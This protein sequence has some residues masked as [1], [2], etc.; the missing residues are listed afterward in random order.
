[1]RDASMHVQHQLQ[2]VKNIC[3]NV[4][5]I[6]I[7]GFDPKPPIYKTPIFQILF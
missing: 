6:Y 2:A 1:M 5:T 4:P 3:S 7:G